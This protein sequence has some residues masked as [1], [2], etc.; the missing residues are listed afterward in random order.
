MFQVCFS[1]QSRFRQI[2]EKQQPSTSIL[3]FRCSKTEISIVSISP[4]RS[5][6]VCTSLFSNCCKKYVYPDTVVKF[7]VNSFELAEA[8]SKSKENHNNSIVLTLENIDKP[9]HITLDFI[10]DTTGEK[11]IPSTRVPILDKYPKFA[12]KPLPD[13]SKASILIT[14]AQELK[15]IFM[16]QTVL[17]AKVEI[18]ID[19]EKVSFNV[20]PTIIGRGGYNIHHNCDYD[21][22]KVHGH[23]YSEDD[24]FAQCP[25]HIVDRNTIIMNPSHGESIKQ[26]FKLNTLAFCEKP[27]TQSNRAILGMTPDRA[28]IIQH[29]IVNYGFVTYYIGDHLIPPPSDEKDVK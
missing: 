29:K 6:I 12:I 11:T 9:T 23:E 1:H 2:I 7:P 18:E 15:R 4:A 21:E 25:K 20:V 28:L 10:N 8:M 19:K 16:S 13:I 14:N 26:T 24:V 5:C 3:V 22:Y 17:S 27:T